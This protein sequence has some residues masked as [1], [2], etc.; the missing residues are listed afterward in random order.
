LVETFKILLGF[1][2]LFVGAR[3]FLYFKKNFVVDNPSIDGYASS[4]IVMLIGVLLIIH[5]ISKIF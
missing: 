5:G 3:M 2:F 1:G 4:L